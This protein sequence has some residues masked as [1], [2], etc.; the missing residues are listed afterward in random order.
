MKITKNILERSLVTLIDWCKKRRYYKDSKVTEFTDRIENISVVKQNGFYH[1]ECYKTFSNLNEV[2]RA[3]KRFNSLNNDKQSAQTMLDR[4]VCR[5]SFK[6]GNQLEYEE[7][8]MLRRS[9]SEPYNKKLCIICQIENK[10]ILHCVQT[11]Q[12]SDKML[13]V[14]QKLS[15]KG[16]YKRLNTILAANDAP[17][18]DVMYHNSCWVNAKRDADK[19]YETFSEKDYINAL[20]DVEIVHFVEKEMADPSG[21]VLD[22]N[23]INEIYRQILSSNGRKKHR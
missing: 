10:N 14:A 8:P 17:A 22:M 18:N 2:K 1:H 23:I 12:M 5:P 11:L 9:Q 21:K 4:K 13:S 16:F 19:T 7:Q 20:S 15:N 3:E 6:Q